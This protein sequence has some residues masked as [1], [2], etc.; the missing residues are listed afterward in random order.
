MQY[1]QR[2]LLVCNIL[3]PWA[4]MAIINGPR[5]WA[6]SRRPPA[7][8]HHRGW[9]VSPQRSGRQRLCWYP[10]AGPRR[11]RPIVQDGSPWVGPTCPAAPGRLET[12]PNAFLGQGA[13]VLCQRPK[14]TAEERPVGGAFCSVRERKAT[15]YACK[16]VTMC[17]RCGSERPSRSSFQTTRQSP[18]RT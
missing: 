15:P 3:K 13:F 11:S 1:S 2:V 12:G 17:K 10:P 8:G 4:I 16:V 6:R 7:P 14:H 9:S 18:G 5:R